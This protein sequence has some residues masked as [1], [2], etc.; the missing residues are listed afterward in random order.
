MKVFYWNI[1][2]ID[3][4]KSHITFKYFN[5]NHHT[6]LMFVD[7]QIIPFFKYFWLVFV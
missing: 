1:R 4:V 2:G 7:E 5:L 6:L 3:T